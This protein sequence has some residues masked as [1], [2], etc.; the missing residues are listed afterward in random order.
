MSHKFVLS[1]RIYSPD[2]R[3]DKRAIF[4][5]PNSPNPVEEGIVQSKTGGQAK[6][7]T[8][9]LNQSEQ[10]RVISDH[11]TRHS[12]HKT[13]SPIYTP[14]HLPFHTKDPNSTSKSKYSRRI[15]KKNK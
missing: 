7:Q 2:T 9:K 14:F 11:K 12:S 13:P 4:V 15:G 3:T 10:E 5:E 8:T 6:K 1:K